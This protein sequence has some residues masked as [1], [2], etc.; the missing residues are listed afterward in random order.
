MCECCY[1]RSGLPRRRFCQVM[2][3]AGVGAAVASAAHAATE[4]PVEPRM[5]LADP[6]GGQLVVALTFDACPGAFDERIATAL[7]ADRIPATLFLTRVWMLRNPA[8]LEFVLAHRDLFAIENHGAVHVPP[9]L[10][11]GSI[12]GIRVAGDL[13]SVEQEVSGGAAAIAASGGG[14]PGWYRAATGFYTPSVIPVIQQMGFGIGGYSL[15]GDMGASLPARSVAARIGGA[16]NGDVVVAH[17]NQPLRPSGLG[18]VAGVR[19]LQRR[20]ASFVRLDRVAV[21]GVVYG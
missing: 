16:R 7:V 21:A 3:G 14:S 12:F 15:N 19:E 17:I 2:L 6:P 13:I 10:G 9:V 8:A 1:T 5:R 4:A 18:V 11:N 20:G